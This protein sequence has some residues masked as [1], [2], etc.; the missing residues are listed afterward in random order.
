M[1]DE[2]WNLDCSFV[3]FGEPRSM[4]YELPH[5]GSLSAS[6][7]SSSALRNT[8]S[9]HFRSSPAV[10]AANSHVFEG[11]RKAYDNTALDILCS[12]Q[13]RYPDWKVKMTPA[14][15]GLIAFADAG[16]ATAKL[17]VES[18]KVLSQ[19]K[20]E[21]AKDRGKAKFRGQVELARY[22]Y[23]WNGNTFIVY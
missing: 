15:T 1:G 11:F 19:L 8:Q 23:Q 6:A 22:D 20:Y 3:E 5:R 7:C 13:S 18:Q 10:E 4:P 2:L 14:S 12:L 16:H 9:Y 17:D 21:P